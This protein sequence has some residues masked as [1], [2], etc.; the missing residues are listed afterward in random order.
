[1][2]ATVNW[3]AGQP[4]LAQSTLPA[5]GALKPDRPLAFKSTAKTLLTNAGTN[6]LERHNGDLVVYKQWLDGS[7]A[8]FNTNLPGAVFDIQND[9]SIGFAPCV[10][11]GLEFFQ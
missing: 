7:V 9:R 3:S 11:T 2:G 8:P 5:M 10:R 1:M 4:P 6:H